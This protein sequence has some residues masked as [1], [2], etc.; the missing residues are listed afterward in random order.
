MPGQTKFV[1]K[2][3]W[4]LQCPTERSG[5]VLGWNVRNF[6]A[7][8]ATIVPDIEVGALAVYPRSSFPNRLKLLNAAGSPRGCF[9]GDGA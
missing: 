9:V 1:S 5:L 6:V 4:P 8:V 7:C 3:F 2:L